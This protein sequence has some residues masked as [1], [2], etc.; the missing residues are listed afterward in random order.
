MKKVFKKIEELIKKLFGRKKKSITD[1]FELIS[2]GYNTEVW[3]TE[4]AG[5]SSWNAKA[6]K[7]PV[8]APDY[9]RLMAEKKGDS[10]ITAAIS[11][12]EAYSDGYFECEARFNSGTA[13]W[14]AIWLCH[15]NGG[16]NNYENYFEVDIS[17]YYNTDSY[18]TTN[19]HCPLTMRKELAYPVTKT[20]INTNGWNKFACK[21]D[22]DSIIVYIN[23][24]AIRTIKNEDNDGLY[25]PLKED[26]RTFKIILSMQYTSKFL[27]EPDFNQLPLWMDVRNIKIYKKK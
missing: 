2:E 4:K 26:Q 21:W 8:V 13:S 23:D 7:W 22:A 25:Y 27:P 17:E 14:P 19:Y 24:K 15:P 11:T 5:S 6:G 16:A 3:K 20:E 12:R 18:T 10:F 9:I 1:G